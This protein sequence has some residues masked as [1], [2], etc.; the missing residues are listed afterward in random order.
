MKDEGKISAAQLRILMVTT[1]LSTIVL[2]LPSLVAAEARQDGWLSIIVGVAG[3]YIVAAVAL[4]LGKRF[5]NQSIIEYSEVILGK[6]IGK[7][8]N[9]TM[10][11]FLIQT[12]SS[13]VREFGEFLVL[14]AMPSTPITVFI[15][16]ILLLAVYASTGG[17]EVIAR[18]NEVFFPATIVVIS[19]IFI[20][21]AKDFEPGNL[22]P[23]LENGPV[24]VLQGAS[25]TLLFFGEIFLVAFLYPKINNPEQI[26]KVT[27]QALA[28]A[29]GMMV[30]DMAVV[31]SLFVPERVSRLVIPLEMVKNIRIAQ[32]IE[33]VEVLAVFIWISGVFI[34]ITVFLY[35]TALATNQWLGLNRQ[36]LLNWP[37]AAILA[38]LAIYS[39]PGILAL[40]RFTYKISPPY[41]LVF[42][43]GIPLLLLIVAAIRGKKG[44]TG[45][46]T[47]QK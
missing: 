12:T 41:F 20:L 39:Y 47:P 42:E 16:V 8:V 40:A 19:S 45:D 23:V 37:L 2:F 10:I 46:D 28:I 32:F 17:L 15:V 22:L 24:P 36:R 31:L 35:V 18:I 14:A 27:Y 33:H 7:I 6:F 26:L 38:P 11:L 5:P 13:I 29:G 3:G 34:K 30:M 21:A 1:V 25:P 44:G 9:L 4:A 43:L